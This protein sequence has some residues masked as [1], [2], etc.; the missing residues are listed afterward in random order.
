MEPA[1]GEGF[2]RCLR[3]FQIA[4][5]DD[6]AAEHNFA[7]RLAVG[8]HARHGLRVHD[9]QAFERDVAHALADFLGVAVVFLRGRP[10]SGPTR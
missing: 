2:V 5:H 10:T 7:Q 1:A 8:G 4:L 6:V 9:G 3:I